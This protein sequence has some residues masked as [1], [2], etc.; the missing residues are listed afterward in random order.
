MRGGLG[1]LL[2][3]L[4]SLSNRSQPRGFLDLREHH[5][6]WKLSNGVNNLVG[7]FHHTFK[8]YLSVA[9]SISVCSCAF[10]FPGL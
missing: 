10:S 7:F 6:L 8:L 9:R 1:D 2:L 5:S 3:D 4:R